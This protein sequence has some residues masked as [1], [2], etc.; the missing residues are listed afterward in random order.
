MK[1]IASSWREC[2]INTVITFL[3]ALSLVS[4]PVRRLKRLQVINQDINKVPISTVSIR[5]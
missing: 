3:F 5:W 4:V 2:K 1:E